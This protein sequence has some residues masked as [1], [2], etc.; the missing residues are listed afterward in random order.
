MFK[1]TKNI[2]KDVTFKWQEIAAFKTYLFALGL[3]FGSFFNEFIK[4]YMPVILFL[5]GFSLGY[6]AMKLYT[7]IFI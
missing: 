7:Q 5:I 6:L 1:F 2:F 3:I 4:D